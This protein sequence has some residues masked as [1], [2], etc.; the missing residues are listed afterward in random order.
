MGTGENKP[1]I[2]F[3]LVHEH[4]NVAQ[5]FRY[6]LDLIYDCVGRELGKIGLGILLGQLSHFRGLQARVCGCSARDAYELHGVAML[7]DADPKMFAIAIIQENPPPL[8]FAT[9]FLIACNLAL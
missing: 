7:Q 5:Q 3:L 4:L 1:T 6:T 2:P 9:H 8:R